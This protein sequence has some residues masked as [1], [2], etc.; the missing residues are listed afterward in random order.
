MLGATLDVGMCGTLSTRAT[1]MAEVSEEGCGLLMC[2]EEGEE[3]E[4]RREEVRL[5]RVG[6]KDTPLVV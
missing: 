1:P 6:L 2:L 5:L 3:G 4:E